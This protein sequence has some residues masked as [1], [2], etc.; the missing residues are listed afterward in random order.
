MGRKG[1]SKRKTRK[2]IIKPL[3]TA[4]SGNSVA[5]L[6]KAASMDAGKADPSQSGAG[7]STNKKKHSK[8]S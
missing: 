3:A 6:V 2:T 7:S 8:K 5:S 4:N 1:D